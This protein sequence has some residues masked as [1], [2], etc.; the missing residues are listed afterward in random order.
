M[1]DLDLAPADVVD[2]IR[3]QNVQVAAGQIG[4]PPAP[5]GQNLQLVVNT[6]RAGSRPSSSS[7]TSS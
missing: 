7:R 5:T 2:A 4:Q 1:T 6:L 3:K